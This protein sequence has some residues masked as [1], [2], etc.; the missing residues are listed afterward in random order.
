MRALA[1]GAWIVALLMAAGDPCRVAAQTAVPSVHEMLDRYPA[2]MADLAFLKSERDFDQFRDQ[3]IREAT[4][5]I[6]AGDAG[7]TRQRE[8]TAAAFALEVAHAGF[9]V[10]WP[11]SRRLVEWGS[12]LLRKAPKPDEGEHLWHLTALTLIQGA[13]DYR[14]LIQQ[15]DDVW[16]KRFPREPRLMFALVVMLDGDT[17]PEPDR[18]VPW[19]ENEAALAAAHKMTQA[20]RM[21]R[22]STTPEMRNKS[23]EY[24]RRTNM[25]QVITLLED[26]SNST[27]LRAEAILRLGVLHLRLRHFEVAQDQ[28]DDVLKLTGEPYLVYLAQFFRGVA[29]EQASDR[30]EAIAAYRAALAVMPRAQA[31]S[32]ALAS[33]LFLQDGRDE[34]SALIDAAIQL[35]TAPDPWRSY[36]SGDFRLWSERVSA[37]RKALR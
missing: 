1:H 9:E 12:D 3:Y 30:A 15:K 18:G 21:T 5:W 2:R 27:E 28:F 34:A 37:L 33:L 22:Q 29:L 17:W 7:S 10:A 35:P 4:G 20:R 16:L 24:Q 23:F 32:F 13:F 8:L 31:A 19:D 25:R 26:L 14:L 11:Q 36:Q 6:R